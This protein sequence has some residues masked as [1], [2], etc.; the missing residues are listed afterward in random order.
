MVRSIFI[1]RNSEELPLL[2]KY[3]TDQNIQLIPQSLVRFEE[4]KHTLDLF[5]EVLFFSS[6]RSAEYFLTQQAILPQTAIAT[7]GAKT[8]EKLE[9]LGLKVDFIGSVAGHPETVAA[10]FSQ[11]LNGRKVVIP[12]S[13]RSN[14]SI[15]SVLPADQVLEIVVYKTILDSKK[16]EDCDLYIFSSP[17]NLE[18]F[19]LQ[20][21][22]PSDS[23][24]IAWG[25]TTEKALKKKGL[26][27]NWVLS[28]S[29]EE[30]VIEILSTKK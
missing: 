27:S 1:S 25:T 4:V 8:A 24:I 11:W 15:A 13:D 19:L 2:T 21:R 26:K 18:A 29:S 7:I 30:E 3:C 20:N 22:I 16:M 9:K 28:T 17:S 14:R 6:I 23:Q 10:E 12:C 5:P